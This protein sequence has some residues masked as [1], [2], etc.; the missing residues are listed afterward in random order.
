MN[1]TK[2]IYLSKVKTLSND[3]KLKP[4]IN[5]SSNYTYCN[6]NTIT[7]SL[8]IE[9]YKQIKSITLYNLDSSYKDINNTDLYEPLPFK[10]LNEYTNENHTTLILK[11]KAPSNQHDFNLLV[12]YYYFDI[13]GRRF[14]KKN[15]KQII[16]N[17]QEFKP[18]NN[19]YIKG[20]PVTNDE[21]FFGRDDIVY[22][23][24]Q[25]LLNDTSN[26]IVIYGQKRSGKTSI[27][28]HV[29][30]KIESTFVVLD[31][32]IATFK[33]ELEA[34][35]AI[36][37]SFEEFLDECDNDNLKTFEQFEI[38]DYQD[39]K[40]YINKASKLAKNLDKQILIMIDEFTSVFE[41][42]KNADYDFDDTFMKRLKEL[43]ELDL[44]KIAVIGQNTMPEFINAYPNEFAVTTPVYINYLEHYDAK[45]LIKK[46]IYNNGENRFLENTDRYIAEIFNGQPYYIQMFC[47]ELVDRINDEL[48]QDEITLAFVEYHLSKFIKSKRKDFFD[49]LVPYKDTKTF[50][51]LTRLSK[52][53]EVFE[54]IFL[55][56]DSIREDDKIILRKLHDNKVIE[57]SQNANTIKFIIPFF[58][59]WLKEQ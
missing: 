31:I 27:F 13:F 55:N 22:N 28:K 4:F 23:L 10:I 20:K 43:I 53:S 26:C 58:Q 25:S 11:V 1:K 35:K 41:Y 9:D 40:R 47:S 56:K 36:K 32:N 19:P 24:T 16:L 42:I 34:Y 33:E 2:D 44:F 50:E 3:I 46:P 30:K 54:D 5:I 21:L 15:N 39:F 12:K 8:T 6:N 59:M 14:D 51:L 38:T 45:N 18:I 29:K 17:T 49:P 52:N 37:S 7:I 57:Y 48:K